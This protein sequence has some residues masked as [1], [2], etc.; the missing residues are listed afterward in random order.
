MR[1][2]NP[3]P[4]VIIWGMLNTKDATGFLQPLASIAAACITLA[5]PDEPNA[6]PA[7]TLQAVASSLAIPAQTAGT[8]ESALEKAASLRPVPRILI[9]GSLY[10]AGH[11]LALHTGED[12]SSVSGAARR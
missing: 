8:L 4:L 1:K 9:C 10:L 3:K 12:M 2:K 6:I 11:V 5:I 7:E